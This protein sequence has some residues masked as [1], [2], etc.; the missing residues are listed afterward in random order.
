MSVTFGQDIW[1]PFRCVLSLKFYFQMY[2]GD[3]LDRPVDRI[4]SFYRLGGGV[5]G[6]QVL[7][8]LWLD[9][10]WMQSFGL[11]WACL[12]LML[13][14]FFRFQGCDVIWL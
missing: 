11:V 10:H 6:W 8:I 12:D 3:W 5:V 13:C 7:V 4:N 9:W 1:Y 2:L 14:D